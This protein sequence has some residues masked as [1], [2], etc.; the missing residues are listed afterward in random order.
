VSW[1]DLT[2]R[3]GTRAKSAAP[4]VC[5][6]LSGV[7]L[8]SPGPSVR[9]AVA[10]APAA[11]ELR[12][13]VTDRLR[14]HGHHRR[15]PCEAPVTPNAMFPGHPESCAACHGSCHRSATPPAKPAK[16]QS[17]SSTDQLRPS[18]HNAQSLWNPGLFNFEPHPGSGS[19]RP[20]TTGVQAQQGAHALRHRPGVRMPAITTLQAGAAPMFS[21]SAPLTNNCASCHNTVCRRPAMRPTHIFPVG[22]APDP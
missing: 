2:A 11:P 14:A 5:R 7:L 6:A 19:A 18:C 4:G 15:P 13:I 1:T 22:H 21:M 8:L 9:R 16:S 20:S 17:P 10:A 12:T 3:C